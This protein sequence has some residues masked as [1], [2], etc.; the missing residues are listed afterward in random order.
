MAKKYG[1]LNNAKLNTVGPGS[2]DFLS[3][4]SLP[5]ANLNFV[6][7]YFTTCR[8]ATTCTHI[9]LCPIASIRFCSRDPS[10]GIND[11]MTRLALFYTMVIITAAQKLGRLGKKGHS[12]DPLLGSSILSNE[13]GIFITARCVGCDGGCI[14]PTDVC[15][16]DAYGA[17]CPEGTY[18]IDGGCCENGQDCNGIPTTCENDNV[19][20]GQHCI[21]AGNTCCQNTGTYCDQGQA[22]QSDGSCTPEGGFGAPNGSGPCSGSEQVCGKGCIPSGSVCCN[23]GYYCYE[24][25]ICMD[26]GGCQG[27][28]GPGISTTTITLTTPTPYT[29]STPQTV[30]STVFVPSTSPSSTET[31]VVS[32]IGGDVTTEAIPVS[33]GPTSTKG[34]FALPSGSGRNVPHSIAAVL[35]LILLIM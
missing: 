27:Q 21:P 23:N 31:V 7:R 20:C 13:L 26:G 28:S 29:S 33:T 9:S 15:C 14:G 19:L 35:A 6:A 30:V 8:L 10:R 2:L 32:A 24:G 3:L 18:C 4:K 25:E 16:G 12:H 5:T 34:G 11:R 1:T 17:Y 22:C